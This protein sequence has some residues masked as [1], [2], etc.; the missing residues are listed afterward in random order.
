MFIWYRIR[1]TGTARYWAYDI[2]YVSID[3]NGKKRG[4]DSGA[5]N[6]WEGNG[7]RKATKRQAATKAAKKV[8]IITIFI[9][10]QSIFNA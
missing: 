10:I 8:S 7:K 9:A 6:D 4:G 5:S 3:R 1:N 2:L